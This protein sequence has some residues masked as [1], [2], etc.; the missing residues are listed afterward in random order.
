MMKVIVTGANG[1]V[2][3]ALCHSL[4]GINYSVVGAVRAAD[5]V[6]AH[7]HY[8]HM[9]VGDIGGATSWRR[10]LQDSDV[11]VHLAART[12]NAS[13]PQALAALR[14]VNVEGTER[15]AYQAAA[16]GVR[17][18]VFVSSIK[19]HGEETCGRS[20]TVDDALSPVDAYARSKLE[21]EQ[22]LRRV[23]AETDMEIVLVRPPLVYGPGV[24]GHFLRLMR[25]IDSGLPLPLASVANQRSLIALDNLVDFLI[26]CIHHPA[27][28]GQA[29][30]ISDGQDLSTPELTRRIASGL[31]RPARLW[32]MPPRLLRAM[33]RAGGKLAWCDRLCGSMQVDMSRTRAVLDWRPPVGVGEAISNTANWY[34]GQ[35]A[36][37]DR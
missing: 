23:A 11:V 34:R 24:K 22:V 3:R 7:E 10:C 30:L 6:G 32:P 14:R 5:R 13:H 31:H 28:A 9:V 18:L 25:W 35:R 8:G 19:V 36:V 29:F 27:A 2:G 20:F 12:Q 1:F 15:L 17:R 21:A 26:L 16:V 33:A 4:I 37:A